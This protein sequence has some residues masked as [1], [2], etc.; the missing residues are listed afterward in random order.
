MGLK[1]LF[2]YFSNKKVL[3]KILEKYLNLKKE[4]IIKNLDKEISYKDFEIIKEYYNEY[5]INKKP[6]E[7]ILKEVD[8][9]WI[10]WKIDERALIPRP[11]TEYLVKYWL[12]YIDKLKPKYIIDIWTWSWIIWLSLAYNR[13]EY[14]YILTDISQDALDLAYENYLLLNKKLNVKFIKSDLLTNIEET[15]LLWSLILSNLPYIPDDV[16]YEMESLSSIKWEP[17]IAFLWWK[18]WLD[19]Y[20]RLIDQLNFD[21]KWLIFEAL[22]WQIDILR[23]YSKKY[24]IYT[25]D[26]FHFNIKIWYLCNIF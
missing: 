12:D 2:K 17:N 20:R 9:Y 13:P 21:F 16:F 15:Y 5:E 18:D 11:E 7:Y 8:F 25:L 24:D 3:Y 10:K 14:N 6:L 22:S 4:D 23:N 26:T 19:L 1:D